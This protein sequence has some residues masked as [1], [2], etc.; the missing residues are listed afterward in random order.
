M[1]SAGLY[2]ERSLEREREE[3]MRGSEREGQVM[4][5]RRRALSTL[6]FIFIEGDR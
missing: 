4:A 5:V 6:G 3:Y 1:S 2:G